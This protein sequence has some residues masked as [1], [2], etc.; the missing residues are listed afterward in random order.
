MVDAHLGHDER[1]ADNLILA[2]QR[3]TRGLCRMAL[4]HSNRIL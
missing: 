1:L 3:I 4:L 2:K